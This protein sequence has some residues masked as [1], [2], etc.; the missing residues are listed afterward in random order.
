MTPNQFYIIEATL[1]GLAIVIAVFGKKVRNMDRIVAIFVVSA[2]NAIAKAV[3]NF[4]RNVIPWVALIGVSYSLG[5]QMGAPGDIGW[6]LTTHGTVI[7]TLGILYWL[8][9]Y[10]PAIDFSK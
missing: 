4:L 9:A 8:L 5:Y 10:G 2:W 7:V 6:K 1:I 3:I